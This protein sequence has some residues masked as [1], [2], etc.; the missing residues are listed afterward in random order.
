MQRYVFIVTAGRTGSTLLAS[1]LSAV[2]RVEIRGENFG[3]VYL[4]FKA[5]EA[6]RLAQ[7]HLGSE[8]AYQSP[9]F[10]AD[11][12][13][14]AEMQQSV[15]ELCRKFVNAGHAPDTL[16]RGFKEVRYDMPDLDDYL[17]FIETV[18]PSARFLF[19][20][21]DTEEIIASGFWKRL[22]S[23]TARARVAAMQGRFRE[24]AERNSSQSFTLDYTDLINPGP[25]LESLF[26]WLDLPY[27]ADS[28]SRLLSIPHSFE[29]SSVL[30]YGNNRLQLISRRAL[31]EHFE[32]FGFDRL[33]VS[34]EGAVVVAGILAPWEP[35]GPVTS[36]YAVPSGCLPDA[37]SRTAGVIGLPSPGA[38]RKFPDNPYSQNARFRL[39][40]AAG[41]GSAD[42]YVDCG[43][44]RVK[45]GQLTLHESE[46]PLIYDVNVGFDAG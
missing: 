43:A 3:F 20:L 8:P 31:H 28:I 25:V 24:F 18:C 23:D 30:F 9:F 41:I 5:L 32:S 11:K 13:D 21:R 36:L 15:V 10:G 29:Q 45:I 7:I 2:P 16:V 22:P 6:V 46:N 39:E 38:H 4:Q 1:M 37:G 34:N 27:H 35:S 17:H 12:L 26:H 44:L 33:S 14:F 42:I 19:L 40:V